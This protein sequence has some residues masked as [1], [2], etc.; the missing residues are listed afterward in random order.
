MAQ[1]FVVSTVAREGGGAVASAAVPPLPCLSSHNSIE[2]GKKAWQKLG[3][4]HRRMAFVLATEVGM[5][6]GRYDIK[7]LGFLTLTFADPVKDIPEAQ[8]RFNSLNT[9]VLRGR[10]SRAIATVERQESGRLHYHLV[11]T[12]GADIKSGVD[13]KALALRDYRSAGAALRA[14]WAFWRQTARKYGFGRTELLP[15]KSTAEAIA[16]YVGKYI[17]KHIDK[18]SKDDVGARL[19]RFLGYE[20]G[21][22]TASA[23]F[24]WNTEGAWLWRMKLKAWAE[25][26]NF[27]DT[28]DIKNLYG[29]RWAYILRETIFSHPISEGVCYPSLAAVNM[30]KNLED[31]LL[32]ARY[33]A[34]KILESKQFVKT[35]I[36]GKRTYHE[37][38]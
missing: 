38:A 20:K 21:E 25:S 1:G 3:G 26:K 27:K 22:R 24:A 10:Y 37:A 15:V 18:R 13:F 36:L 11:V 14:E 4:P 23:N 28:S 5:L 32:I 35:Y 9:N 29:P 31:P 30:A 12:L 17:S 7:K 33:R 8:R 6:A 34:E 2:E 16:R 19:V